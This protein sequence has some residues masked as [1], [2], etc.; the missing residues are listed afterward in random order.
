[1]QIQCTLCAVSHNY[2]SLLLV[3]KFTHINNVL[4]FWMNCSLKCHFPMLVIQKAQFKPQYSQNDHWEKKNCASNVMYWEHTVA[5]CINNVWREKHS[6]RWNKS[7]WPTPCHWWWWQW[8]TRRTQEHMYMYK[9]KCWSHKRLEEIYAKV[10][11]IRFSKEMYV[12]HERIK[13]FKKCVFGNDY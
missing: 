13:H 2:C 10:M 7:G 3:P 8:W 9:G 12:L 5:T 4:L 1:M 6:W 11:C